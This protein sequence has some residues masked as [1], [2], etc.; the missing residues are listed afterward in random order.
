VFGDAP[1]RAEW[2]EINTP[3]QTPGLRTVYFDP[4]STRR[5]GNFVTVVTLVDWRWMQGNRSPTRFYSTK[6]TKQ[7]DCAQKRLRLLTYS[8]FLKH[9]GTGRRND[10]YVDQDHW[11]PVRPETIDQA[12]WEL[13]CGKG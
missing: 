5:D 7:F 6:L 4:V 12:L 3:Y 9:M 13:A 1:V 10:G 11:L 8:E 2:V